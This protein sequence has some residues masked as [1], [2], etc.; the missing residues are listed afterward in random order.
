M[1]EGNRLESCIKAYITLER[2]I[3]PAEAVKN[4]QIYQTIY[5]SHH[6]CFQQVQA[7]ETCL[8]WCGHDPTKHKRKNRNAKRN[9]SPLP[10][11]RAL[12]SPL[13]PGSYLGEEEVST[14]PLRF[15]SS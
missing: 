6:D 12:E 3:V 15:I 9:P 8:S 1:I 10:A 7:F 14:V 13:A 11:L 2:I 5:S 4:I